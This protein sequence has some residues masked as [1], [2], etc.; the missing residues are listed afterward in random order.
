MEKRL[1]KGDLLSPAVALPLL[2]FFAIFLLAFVA[3]SSLKS[4][5]SEPVLEVTTYAEYLYQSQFPSAALMYL[6]YSDG[7]SGLIKLAEAERSG[8]LY[9][10]VDDKF[11]STYVADDVISQEEQEEISSVLQ[12]FKDNLNEG[13]TVKRDFYL[14]KDAHGLVVLYGAPSSYG[15]SGYSL[16][17]TLSTKETVPTSS[18]SDTYPTK[19]SYRSM[20]VFS[21][22]E[23]DKR[24]M[25]ILCCLD[26]KSCSD[27][28]AE[29]GN[30]YCVSDPCGQGPCTVIYDDDGKRKCEDSIISTFEFLA[31]FEGGGDDAW[32]DSLSGSTTKW[33]ALEFKV[34]ATISGASKFTRAEIDF[35]DG[36]T[37]TYDLK[38][39]SEGSGVYGFYDD[40][41]EVLIYELP[42]EQKEYTII[43]KVWDVNGY[44]AEQSVYVHT[45]TI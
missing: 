11:L 37:E 33:T 27:Y 23:S 15:D 4:L 32:S 45:W 31:R 42:H 34:E 20:P 35:G 18:F 29:A 44:S 41:G 9:A 12:T 14:I 38:E 6:A 22:E 5:T 3:T 26:I 16:W 8:P 30:N 43:C 24:I 17:S 19:C 10:E 2:V 1:L 39:S 7:G 40:S 13:A 21:D 28:G 36:N 25:L